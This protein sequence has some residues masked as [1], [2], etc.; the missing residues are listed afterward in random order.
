MSSGHHGALEIGPLDRLLNEA[1]LFHFFDE[2]VRI[3]S[4]GGPAFWIAD[5]K[6]CHHVASRHNTPPWE[7][8]LR[9]REQVR[10]ITI[11]VSLA[12]LEHFDHPVRR[13]NRDRHANE[14][15]ILERLAELRLGYA[16]LRYNDS[17]SRSIDVVQSANRR[18]CWHEKTRL[19]LDVGC[20]KVNLS[21]QCR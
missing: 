4:A 1:A 6:Y 14:F 11:A 10:E 2:L 5:R 7:V 20:P 3:G 17:E 12:V 19:V 8:S 9:E 21:S 16:L 18:F 13:T 15:D